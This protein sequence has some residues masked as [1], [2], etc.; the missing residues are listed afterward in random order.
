[1]KAFAKL[2]STQLLALLL[3]MSVAFAQTG[4]P[5]P[6]KA[7]ATQPELD[8]LLAPIA[9]YPDPLLSQ[10][11][12]ASTYPLEVVEAAR[13][14][15]ANSGLKGEDAV[16]AVE[17]KD[18]DPS[19]KSLVAFPQVLAMMDEKL[20]WT[21]RL[22]DVFVVQEPQVME[23]VQSLRQKAYEAGN[24]RSSDRAYVSQQGETIVVEP[25]SPEVVYVPYYDPW[26]AYGPWW[27]PAYPPV[28]W[29][30]WPG[31]YVSP[32]FAFAWGG[33]IIVGARF[34]FGGCDWRQ[35]HVTVL[36]VT[37][38]TNVTNVVNR[39]VIVKGAPA[40]WQHDP[41]HRRGVPYHIPSAQQRFGRANIALASERRTIHWQDSM[42]PAT[43]NSSLNRPE[44]H[45]VNP[46]PQAFRA[47]VRTSPFRPGDGRIG[48]SDGRGGSFVPPG[49][50]RNIEARPEIRSPANRPP[51]AAAPQAPV[52]SVNVPHR[53]GPAPQSVPPAAYGPPP[54][55]HGF[56]GVGKPGSQSSPGAAK[57]RGEGR[58]R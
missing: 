49:V 29:A 23:T 34:F 16:N 41:A 55:A 9:L 21:E 57:S 43:R 26:V 17:R 24:L 19:V 11:L 51:I 47:D 13:W 50:P 8:Q 40:V 44:A 6:G 22:G 14:S 33:G 7:P 39:Q 30:P 32:G 5:A 18:W 37:N 31:Y 53:Q 28:Y 12:M 3:S 15:R 46:R 45:S 35:R 25:A 48:R 52:G 54:Q 1:M 10:I 58:G 2:A 27:W 42:S 56:G 20:D 4:P 38:V 36:N